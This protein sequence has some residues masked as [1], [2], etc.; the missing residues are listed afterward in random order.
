MARKRYKITALKESARWRKRYKGGQYYFPFSEYP[1]A[2]SAWGAWLVKKA[3][4][5][6]TLQASKPFKAEYEQAIRDRSDLAQWCRENGDQQQAKAFQLEADA[7]LS[8]FNRSASPPPLS[9]A[10][11][12]PL[13]SIYASTISGFGVTSETIAVWRDRL[14]RIRRTAEPSQAISKHIDAYLALKQTKASVGYWSVMSAH[15][16][17]FQLWLG[18]SFPVEAITSKTLYEFYLH[19]VGLAEKGDISR[20]YAQSTFTTTRQWVKWCWEMELCDLPRNIA[21]RE[22]RFDVKPQPIITFTPEEVKQLYRHAP[23]RTKLYIL[24]ACN[25]GYTQSDVSALRHDEVDWVAGTITRKRTKTRDHENV[26]VV[27]YPLWEP[28]LQ[29]LRKHR[30]KHPDLVLTTQA[31]NPLKREKITKGYRKT[32]AVAKAFQRLAKKAD[33]GQRGY[34]HFRKTGATLLGEHRDH[35]A[36][37]GL[38]LGHAPQSIAERH[39]A[40]YSQELF[41]EAIEWLGERLG[42]VKT[43]SAAPQHA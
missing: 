38:Y 26:P 35:K 11:A 34:K 30:S 14:E 25:C 2:E 9:P 37:V 24:L 16:K 1:T 23:S 31:G 6:L 8:R 10:D 43:A 20:K 33:M 39:Y 19:L 32:D 42:F 27:C 36:Y 22:L 40:G 4:I 3:E 13:G 21:S 15:L 29:L 18:A 17:R 28:T 5:D 7:L 12:D 41:N